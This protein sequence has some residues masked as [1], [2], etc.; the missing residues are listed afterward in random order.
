MTLKEFKDSLS[1]S[2]PDP[3]TNDYL[4]A[5]WYD[6]KDDWEKAHNIVQDIETSDA[7][8]IHAYLHRKEGDLGNA[9][10]WYHRAHRKL[11]KNS[12]KVEWEDM[13]TE[14]LQN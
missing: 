4:K 8:H 13:V 7:A 14:Y 6:G 12:L 10:Y 2:Q 11:P 5:L 3:G 9:S 1:N